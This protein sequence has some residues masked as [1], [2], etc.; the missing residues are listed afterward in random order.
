M[1]VAPGV[2]LV[3]TAA[4][5]PGANDISP[6]HRHDEPVFATDIVRY[7]GQ[8]L[9]AVAASTR[10]QARAA[11]RL[12]VVEYEELDA[13]LDVEA[14]RPG[15]SFVT[16]PMAMRRGDAAAAIAGA[17][18]RLQGRITMGG[19]DHFYLEGQ[20]AMALPGE[21][22]EVTVLTSSQHPSEIQHMVAPC[23][24]SPTTR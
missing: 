22:D 5:I 14:A 3:L 18:R 19:Q 13:V 15:Q 16:E 24:G 7:A 1:G 12:A 8:P 10:N 9:F 20:I 23:W 21:E 4:D 11:V 17:P 6:T 2:A